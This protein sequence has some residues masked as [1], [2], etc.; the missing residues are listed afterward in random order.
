MSESAIVAGPTTDIHTGTE[1]LTTIAED[2]T[3]TGIIVAEVGTIIDTTDRGPFSISFGEVSVLQ[4]S[5][6]RERPK[7]D[8]IRHPFRESRSAVLSLSPCAE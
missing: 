7:L 1:A 2:Y 5:C 4:M 6:K 3:A 8:M